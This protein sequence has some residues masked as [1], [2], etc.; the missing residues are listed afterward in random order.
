MMAAPVVIIL[1][2]VFMY[3]M[4]HSV[5]ASLAIKAQTRSAFGNLAGRG[6]RMADNV[7]AFIGLL[8][9]LA[10]PLLLPDRTLYRISFP[11]WVDYRFLPGKVCIVTWKSILLH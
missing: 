2:A 11:L 5:L 4:I 3:G 7:F 6:Y 1:F 10:L 9:V 8:P